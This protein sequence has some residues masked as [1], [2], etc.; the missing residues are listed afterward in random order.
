MLRFRDFRFVS[1]ALAAACA[2]GLLGASV[3]DA[4]ELSFAVSPTAFAKGATSDVLLIVT[5]QGSSSVT[6]PVWDHTTATE[7][8]ITVGSELGTLSS[9]DALAEDSDGWTVNWLSVTMSSNVITVHNNVTVPAWTFPQGKSFAVHAKFVA[10]ANQGPGSFGLTN[11]PTG[12]SVASPYASVGVVSFSVGPAGATGNTGA[13]GP[14]GATG[15]DGATG[16]TGAQGNDGPAGP[17]GPVGTPGVTGATGPTGNDGLTGPTGNDGP[18]GATGA[19]GPAGDIGPTGPQGDVGPTGAAGAGLNW[20]SIWSSSASYDV[21]DAVFDPATSS[22][23]VAVNPNSGAASEPV[24]DSTDWALLAGGG[25]TGPAGPQ[26]PTGPAGV[27]AVGPTGPQGPTGAAGPTGANGTGSFTWA[28]EWNMNQTYNVDAAVSENGSSYVALTSTT[29]VDPAS[30]VASSGGNWALIAQGGAQGSPGSQGPAGAQGPQGPAGPTGADG[31]IGPAGAD[32]ATGATGPTGADGA[33]GLAGPAGPTGPAG[34]N[35]RGP[36]SST[37]QYEIGD[38][39][40]DAGSSYVAVAENSGNDPVADS[41]SNWALL[42]A[43]GAQGATG[44]AGTAGAQGVTGAV[45]PTGPAGAAGPTGAAG[46]A[47]PQG[48]TGALGPTGP[49]LPGATGATGSPGPQGATGLVGPTGSGCAS[50]PGSAN[51]GD[52]TALLT[53]VPL[54]LRRR[55]RG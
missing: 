44:P 10:E 17:T 52:L 35:W 7:W 36:W 50:V 24:S 18:A 20:R 38:A 55:R 19:Q 26:G 22:S 4:Q 11:V 43:A 3:A 31:S 6:V 45:G 30:D 2:A 12:F 32:G 16:A 25:A 48:V 49:S 53:L 28:G 8:Q 51:L 9:V 13:T 39:V 40:S 1:S 54:Y 15:S 29:G 37:V 34:F 14:T 46:I 23:Y 21:N 41:G 27:G 47:G 5:N 33:Q 42:A